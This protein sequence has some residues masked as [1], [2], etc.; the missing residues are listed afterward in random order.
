V[1]L[2][3]FTWVIHAV[4]LLG[5]AW[6]ATKLFHVDFARLVRITL[7]EFKDLS[8]LRFT[9]GSMN[10]LGIV[11]VTIFGLVVIGTLEFEELMSLLVSVLNRDK[12]EAFKQLATIRAMFF[13]VGGFWLASM[14]FVLIDNWRRRGQ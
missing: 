12:A 5:L 7:E 6:L 14:V 10:M 1:E 2:S 8:R 13:F 11:V 4:V 9:L 3:Q